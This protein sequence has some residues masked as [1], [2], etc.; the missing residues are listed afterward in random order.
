MTSSFSAHHKDVVAEW[1]VAKV[2]GTIDTIYW[3]APGSVGAKDSLVEVHINRSNIYPGRG[4]GYKPY[5]APC[6]QWGYYRN[7]N[8]LDQGITPYRGEATD[9]QW[10]STT[11]FGDSDS[12]D[13]LGADMWLGNGLKFVDHTNSINVVAMDEAGDRPQVNTG[14]AFFI[15]FRINSFNGHPLSPDKPTEFARHE[16][17]TDLSSEDYPSRNWTFY[18][19]DSA[20]SYCGLLPGNFVRQGWIAEGANYLD[21]LEVAPFNIWYAMTVDTNMPYP[22]LLEPRLDVQQ[23]GI[24]FCVKSCNASLLDTTTITWVQFSSG[25]AIDSL[26]IHLTHDSV[27]CTFIPSLPQG[28]VVCFKIAQ[29]DTHGVIAYGPSFCMTISDVKSTQQPIPESFTL[30]Q[31][32][33]NPF[34]PIT[35]FGFRISDFSAGGGSASGGGFV[36]L[37]VLDVLGRE[38]AT[39]VNER[40]E[41]GEYTV[42][43]DATGF[44]SG[45]YFCK[46]TAGT[47]LDT[48]KLL[49]L[50]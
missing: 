5:R 6:T 1:F 42:T 26:P 23:T 34:N 10:I 41:P 20:P 30:Y 49:L 14:D 27:S 35:H 31:N 44:T 18:E 46:L 45:V 21:S 50:K 47:F 15:S 19:H 9:T 36:S 22:G 39:L 2:K 7:A 12:F 32:Y 40:K 37:K 17:H 8:D 11:F 48:K 28:S 38:V 3:E 16:F 33:P 13:P 24:E 29:R 43:W 25:Y 4:P